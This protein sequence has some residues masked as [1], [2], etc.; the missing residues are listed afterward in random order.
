MTTAHHSGSGDLR[1]SLELLWHGRERPGRGPKP[2]LSLERIVATAVALADRDGLDA[3]SMR[4]VAG[5]LGVGT[6]SLYRYVPGKGELLDLMLDHIEGEL[7]QTEPFQDTDWRRALQLIA[8]SNLALCTEHPWLLQVN[9]TRPLLGPNALANFDRALSAL[10]DLPLSGREKVQIIVVL[11][12]YVT[13][14]ARDHVLAQEV[15]A[16]SGV[17]D[18]EFW[19]IQEPLLDSALHSG[20]YPRILTLPEDV[21][22]ADADGGLQ[23]GLDR[24]FDGIAVLLARRAGA[25]EPGERGER[26]EPGAP[27]EAGEPGGAE[28]AADGAAP[29]PSGERARRRV[30][31]C[32]D[33]PPAPP[34]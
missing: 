27:G 23:F 33:A 14:V 1:R 2:G 34:E 13:G 12:A 28:G 30:P 26:G 4:R 32:G 5:E 3:L 19:R 24:L 22:D 10:D 21:F 7:G 31:T 11:N 9:Q 17:S 16:Q 29:A 6:M 25:R 8:E 20:R 18:E 15:S